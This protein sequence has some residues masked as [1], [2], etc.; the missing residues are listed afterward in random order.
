VGILGAAGERDKGERLTTRERGP[1]WGRTE[2]M[3]EEEREE[4][5]RAGSGDWK[6]TIWCTWM[7]G[8]LFLEY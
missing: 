3:E 1:G 4:R 8:F 2:R 7:T 6:M 5:R